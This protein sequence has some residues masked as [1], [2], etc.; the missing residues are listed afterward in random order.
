MA[1]R[2][3]KT[4]AWLTSLL[5]VIGAV[6][7]LVFVVKTVHTFRGETGSYAEAEDRKFSDTPDRPADA[8]FLDIDE[9]MED[10]EEAFNE[11]VEDAE[12]IWD[13]W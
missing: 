6:Y 8:T 4:L 13:E 3:N 12:E 10:A 9:V 2:R 7:V 11:V 5:T 1:S